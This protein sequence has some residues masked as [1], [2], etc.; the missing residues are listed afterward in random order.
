MTELQDWDVASVELLA[1]MTLP[2]KFTMSADMEILE[3]KA[4]SL[5]SALNTI[6]ETQVYMGLAGKDLKRSTD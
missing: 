6:V 1:T 5:D 3:I 2:A 4:L